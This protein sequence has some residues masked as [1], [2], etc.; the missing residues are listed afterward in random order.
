M[1]LLS[2]LIYAALRITSEGKIELDFLIVSPLNAST[3]TQWE[4]DR[5]TWTPYLQSSTP[6]KTPPKL[7]QSA[8]ARPPDLS[9]TPPAPISHPEPLKSVQSN[10][11][12]ES[13]ESATGPSSPP[14]PSIVRVDLPKL[15][16]LMRMMGDLVMCAIA[17]VQHNNDRFQ[18]KSPSGR[19][20]SLN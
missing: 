4:N 12:P 9:P 8:E 10:P 17:P 18:T 13:E 19:L 20:A 16:E 3:F 15:D 11:Q 6:E 7:P 14:G 1:G 5:L 2:L